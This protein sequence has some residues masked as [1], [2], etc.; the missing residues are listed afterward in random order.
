MRELVTESDAIFFGKV[1][2]EGEN[3]DTFRIEVD[4]TLVGNV[5][6]EESGWEVP[7]RGLTTACRPSGMFHNVLLHPGRSYIF[8]AQGPELLRA[9]WL[10]RSPRDI[11]VRRE[12]QIVERLRND[13]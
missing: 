4:E 2:S 6:A 5:P 7:N 13:T 9:G 8:Y 10:E 3:L 11:S 12:R 1:A